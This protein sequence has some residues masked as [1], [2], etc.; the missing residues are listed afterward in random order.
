VHHL[1]LPTV[2]L[3]GHTVVLL[4]LMVVQLVPDPGLLLLSS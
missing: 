4:G 3:Q 1:Q 2:A